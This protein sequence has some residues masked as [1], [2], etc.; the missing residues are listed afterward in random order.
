MVV[1]AN[2]IT[3]TETDEHGDEVERDIPFLRAYTVFCVDQIEACRITI[4]V[5]RLRPSR[6]RS[7]SRMRTLSSPT[8]ARPS[9]MAATR[10]SSRPRPTTSRCRRSKVSATPRAMSHVWR[11]KACIGPRPRIAPIAISA[12]TQRIAANARAKNWSPSLAACFLCADLG[13]VPELEPRPDHASYLASWLEVL[14]NDK[15]FIFSA[16]AHAQRAVAY[17]HELQPKPAEI[18]EAA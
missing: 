4:T 6:R 18:D 11:M 2:R 8:P 1:Y 14:S 13:I 7:A 3:K 10:R 5:G 9:G 12:A 16:A 15:R 17:L